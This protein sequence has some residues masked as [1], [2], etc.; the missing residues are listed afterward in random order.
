M[1]RIDRDEDDHDIPDSPR[2]TW[3]RRALVWALALVGLG[4]GFLIPY[5][6]YLNQQ[7]SERFGELRW[8]VPTRVY[9]RPLHLAPGMAL[10]A[11][12]LKLELE[13]SAYREGDGR[14][15]GTWS[16]AENGRWTISSRARA[17][18]TSTRIPAVP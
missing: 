5:T 15:P 2:R 13:S 17:P 11:Q 18:S 8:Q 3:S 14:S 16:V 7:V 6:V 4:L 10:D 12:T 1:R 9:A